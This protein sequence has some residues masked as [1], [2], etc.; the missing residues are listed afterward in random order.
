M[1]SEKGAT[2]ATVFLSEEMKGS[3][4]KKS[5][6]VAGIKMPSISLRL[7]ETVSNPQLDNHLE[8]PNFKNGALVIGRALTSMGAIALLILLQLVVISPIQNAASQFKATEDIRYQLANGTAPTG[9]TDSSG[10][11]LK[12]GTPVG[13]I[14][15]KKLG[16]QQVILEG[17]SSDITANGPGHRRDTVLPGQAGI[18]V[19]YGR[20]ASYGGVFGGISTLKPG[21]EITAITGQGESTYIVSKVRVAGDIATNNLG[22]SK[23]RLTLVTAAG[24][25]FLPSEV[26]RVEAT[27]TSEAKATPI[28]TIQHGAIPA[29]E[30]A[31]GSQENALTPLIYLTVLLALIYALVN[32]LSRK[33]GKVQ[34]WLVAVPLY[35]YFGTMW[36]SLVIQLLPNLI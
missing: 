17:T 14:I 25:P 31:L 26:I 9:Q 4:L 28:R 27:L 30:K 8:L 34:S 6:K 13:I 23:G 2:P 21:D 3:N 16:I 33:W 7:P 12:A 24:L 36:A 32:W 5:S 35:A 22:D 18:S 10:E 11:L 29:S 20:Q 1:V 19:I 15:I